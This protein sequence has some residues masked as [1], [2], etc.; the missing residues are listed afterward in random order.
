MKVKG[1]AVKAEEYCERAILAK[2]NDGNALSLYGDLI[3]Q[4]HRDEDR[5][6]TYFHQAV[7]SSPNDW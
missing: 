2:P 3:W 6:Q 5:A 4:T 1:D 7:N